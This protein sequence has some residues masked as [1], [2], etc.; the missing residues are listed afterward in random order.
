MVS[1]PIWKCLL[2]MQKTKNRQCEAIYESIK[3]LRRQE[4]DSI[5]RDY[6]KS[7]DIPLVEIPYTEFD[8]IDTIL[9]NLLKI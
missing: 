1:L 3:N 2:Q 8:N 4:T 9:K 7:H 6:C 5:K